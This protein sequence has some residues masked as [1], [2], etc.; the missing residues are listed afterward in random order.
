MKFMILIVS[1]LIC[2][3]APSSSWTSISDLVTFV[4]NDTFYL[5][6]LTTLMAF[7]SFSTVVGQLNASYREAARQVTNMITSVRQCAS[8]TQ[9]LLTKLQTMQNETLLLQIYVLNQVGNS[10]EVVQRLPNYKMLLIGLKNI[11][12]GILAPILPVLFI[13][14]P[15]STLNEF[16]RTVQ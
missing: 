14:F 11:L 5:Q 2:S 8:A 16:F 7:V 4:M 15:N 1:T 6:L 3:F 13:L 10:N 12:K 9:S